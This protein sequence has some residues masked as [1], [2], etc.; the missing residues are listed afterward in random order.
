MVSIIRWPF[1]RL[2]YA[3]EFVDK[4]NPMATSFERIAAASPLGF[5]EKL[6]EHGVVFVLRLLGSIYRP[7]ENFASLDDVRIFGAFDR[8]R[9]LA[10]LPGSVAAT[11][12]AFRGGHSSS[13]SGTS[14]SSSTIGAGSATPSAISSWCSSSASTPGRVHSPSARL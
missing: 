14:S 6:A 5:M 3:D 2:G 9:P 1:G 12:P 8:S 4:S 13:T 10:H 11:Y 7:T